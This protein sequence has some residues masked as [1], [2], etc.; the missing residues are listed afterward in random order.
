MMGGS[1]ALTIAMVVVMV[2]MMGGMLVAGLR[3]F[4]RR[5][6]RDSDD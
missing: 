5:R 2:V 1:A 6:S 4:A 3:A